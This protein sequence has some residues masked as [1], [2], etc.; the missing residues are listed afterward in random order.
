MSQRSPA[1]HRLAATAKRIEAGL[2]NLILASQLLA[3][4]GMPL[5]PAVPWA[6]CSPAKEHGLIFVFPSRNPFSRST[7][8]LTLLSALQA[9]GTDGLPPCARRAAVGNSCGSSHT[10]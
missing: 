3:E 7:D 9:G 1:T 6:E 10:W 8:L 5:V 4:E 2:V